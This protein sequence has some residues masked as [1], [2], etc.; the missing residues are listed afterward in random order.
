MKHIHRLIVTSRAYRLSSSN[1][2]VATV[3]VRLDPDNHFL[4]RFHPRRMEAQLVR[5]SLLA[6]SGELDLT[7]GGPSVPVNQESRRRSLYYVHSHNEHQKFLSTFDDANVLECYRRAESIVPQQALALEN[8]PLASIAAEKIVQRVAATDTDAFLRA[9]FAMILG[10]TPQDEELA[11][12]REAL[13]EWTTQARAAQ[14]ADPERHARTQF[15]QA[16]LNHNDFIVI[17]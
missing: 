6:L 12:S 15:V 13:T 14:R 5:D 9:G 16:L 3:N 4:W 10:V 7:L 1:A 8:S 17:R 11:V 2:E